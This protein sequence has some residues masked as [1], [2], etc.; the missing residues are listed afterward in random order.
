MPND[1]LKLTDDKLAATIAPYV[2]MNGNSK[3]SL[4]DEWT[5]FAR[6][7][8]QAIDEAPYDSFHGRN[9]YPKSEADQATANGVRDLMRAQLTKM[10]NL[11][12]EV[13]LTIH[14]G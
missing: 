7:I 14:Q 3:D 2:H 6:R 4:V 12:E 5:N 9:Q 8:T 11:A 1:T 13:A 10:H